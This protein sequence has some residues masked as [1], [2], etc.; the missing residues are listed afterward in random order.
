MR[1]LRHVGME[2]AGHI[3]SEG[4]IEARTHSDGEVWLVRGDNNSSFRSFFVVCDW[5]VHVLE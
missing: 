4:V 3:G 1:A 2:L 5:W